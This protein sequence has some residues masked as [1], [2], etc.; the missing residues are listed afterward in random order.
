[1]VQSLLIQNS[2]GFGTFVEWLSLQLPSMAW[3]HLGSTVSPKLITKI[4]L[5][6]SAKF[7]KQIDNATIK[8]KAHA[9]TQK[10]QLAT[11]DMISISA[12]LV[13]ELVKKRWLEIDSKMKNRENVEFSSEVSHFKKCFP[14]DERK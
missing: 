1:M 4:G 11:G 10:I 5:L 7:L 3:P 2:I 8:F 12:H 13:E 14:K 6:F 9:E